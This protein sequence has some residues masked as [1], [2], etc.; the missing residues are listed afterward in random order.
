M[1]EAACFLL[2]K[3]F[4][5]CQNFT[6]KLGKNAMI[7]IQGPDCLLP[8]FGQSYRAVCLIIDQPLFRQPL[9]GI[10]HRRALAAHTFGK[11]RGANRP[12]FLLQFGN[13][14]KI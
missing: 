5:K 1:F 12:V 6:E 14:F 11:V 13:L 2:G 9:Q 8:F 3:V 7:P 10:G 4:R